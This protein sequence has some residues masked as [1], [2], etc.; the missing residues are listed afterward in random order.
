[1]IV[2]IVTSLCLFAA[3][4]I[5]SDVPRQE[6]TGLLAQRYRQLGGSITLIAKPGVGHHPHGLDD[7]TP[8]VEFITR[9]AAVDPAQSYE[10]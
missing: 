5:A 1:M 6:N 10:Q 2:R 7:P 9:H 3:T 8:I 4:L